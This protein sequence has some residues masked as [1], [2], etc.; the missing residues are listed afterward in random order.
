MSTIPKLTPEQVA[1]L[2]PADS[3]AYERAL[4]AEAEERGWVVRCAVC[5]AEE[6][7]L[8]EISEETLEGDGWYLGFNVSLCPEHYDEDGNAD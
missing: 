6:T 5:D 8:G 1:A 2:S 3:V 4:E 7:V